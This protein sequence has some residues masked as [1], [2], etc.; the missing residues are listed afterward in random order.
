[1]RIKLNGTGHNKIRNRT[2]DKAHFF[3]TIDPLNRQKVDDAYDARI[4][5]FISE[6]Y[7]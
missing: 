2:I 3:A 7:I 5:Q 6:K 4:F 1:M